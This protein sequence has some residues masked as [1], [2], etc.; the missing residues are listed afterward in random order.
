MYRRCVRLLQ[1]CLLAARDRV[2]STD[3]TSPVRDTAVAR[4]HSVLQRAHSVQMIELYDIGYCQARFRRLRDPLPLR[5]RLRLT[6][7]DAG[8]GTQLHVALTQGGRHDPMHDP[9]LAKLIPSV[10]LDV[11]CWLVA[12][13]SARV[14]EA[15]AVGRIL[16]LRLDLPQCG[17]PLWRKRNMVKGMHIRECAM[18]EAASWCRG[19][20]WSCAHS[21]VMIQPSFTCPAPPCSCASQSP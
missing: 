17:H 1:S 13:C 21:T 7:E 10:E 15:K 16:T 5:F 2:L 19:L 9:A 11:H 20:H 4:A 14:G 6:T 18:P 3:V 8:D 12:V